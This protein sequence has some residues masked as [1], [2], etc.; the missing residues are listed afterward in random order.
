MK[1]G[2]KL[3]ESISGLAKNVGNAF[4]KNFA[5]DY[6]VECC[7][8]YGAVPF[9]NEWDLDAGCHRWRDVWPGNRN[10]VPSV[11]ACAREW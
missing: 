6:R 5:N 1:A 3:I 7:N 2:T 9:S 10:R 4:D 11:S 8:G